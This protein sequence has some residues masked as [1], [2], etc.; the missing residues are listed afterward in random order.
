MNNIVHMLYV[1]K[2]CNMKCVYCYEKW[3]NVKENLTLKQ[4]MKIIYN[5]Y[6]NNNKS[7]TI[8]FFGGEPL[9]NYDLIVNLCKVR[10]QLHLVNPMQFIMTTNGS[11][12]TPDKIDFLW[13]E[14]VR[15]T[16]SYDGSL[17]NITRKHKGILNMQKHLL[18]ILLYYKE[19]K[20]YNNLRLS[21]CLMPEGIPDLLQDVEF[22]MRIYGDVVRAI[23]FSPYNHNV[24]PLM[25]DILSQLV[26]KYG[27]K[28]CP[29][30]CNICVF[31]ECSRRTDHHHAANCIM[32][33]FDGNKYN[34]KD[35]HP[36]LKES[37]IR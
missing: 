16:L 34:D 17:T 12:L 19:K 33:D 26:E 2:D 7:V 27:D 23:D 30:L 18:D 35:V 21:W 29:Y 36:I 3:P 14:N 37:T 22:I 6:K 31:K 20:Y 11:L 9:L 8:A 13:K 25:K 10:S 28:I 32:Y 5:I 4:A 1:T 15:I 24:T